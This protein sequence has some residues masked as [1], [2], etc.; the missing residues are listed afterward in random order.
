MLLRINNPGLPWICDRL[1]TSGGVFP[2]LEEHC[3]VDCPCW[4]WF[5]ESRE[6]TLGEWLE[7]SI[8][9]EPVVDETWL[10]LSALLGG[11]EFELDEG[12]GELGISLLAAVIRLIGW[13]HDFPSAQVESG[14]PHSSCLTKAACLATLCFSIN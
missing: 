4:W 12:R 10:L 2:E 13:E 9:P 1:R 14:Q 6:Y 8:E 11:R 7:R 3:P 5:L